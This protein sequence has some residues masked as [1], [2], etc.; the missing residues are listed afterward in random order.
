MM[1]E[2]PTESDV[3]ANIVSVDVS[4]SFVFSVGIA[5]PDT[6]CDQYANWWEVV[7]PGGTLLYRRILAHS[8]ITEQPFCAL[9]RPR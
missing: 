9:R 7:T 5:S 6:G 2:A 3:L 4:A 1:E 8:H